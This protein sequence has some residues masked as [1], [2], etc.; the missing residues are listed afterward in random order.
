MY[1]LA[2]AYGKGVLKEMKD[3]ENQK[4]YKAGLDSIKMTARTRSGKAKS[5][6]MRKARKGLEQLSNEKINELLLKYPTIHGKKERK[7]EDQKEQR[8]MIKRLKYIFL[9]NPS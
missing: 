4:H 7:P 2:A 5:Y 8:S 6:P 1:S 3:D 9:G